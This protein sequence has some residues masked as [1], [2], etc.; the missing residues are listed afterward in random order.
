MTLC[1]V[2]LLLGAS[3]SVEFSPNGL[4]PQ[5]LLTSRYLC[6]ILRTE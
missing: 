3:V 4:D 5:N 1:L 6:A 2:S